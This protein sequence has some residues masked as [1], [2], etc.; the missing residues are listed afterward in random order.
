VI[1]VATNIYNLYNFSC[2]SEVAFNISLQIMTHHDMTKWTMDDVYSQHIH[3]HPLAIHITFAIKSCFT[4]I[5]YLHYLP[6]VLN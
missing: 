2:I 5:I 4:I 1:I 3:V 6:H